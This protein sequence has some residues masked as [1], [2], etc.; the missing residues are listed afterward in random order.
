MWFLC[1]C[2]F[3]VFVVEENSSF[4]LIAWVSV[5]LLRLVLVHS[6]SQSKCLNASDNRVAVLTFQSW[7]S[8]C[9]YRCLHKPCKDTRSNFLLVN[10]GSDYKPSDAPERGVCVCVC[11]GGNNCGRGGGVDI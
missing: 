10:S 6:V 5:H 7:S 11:D 8:T 4:S 1:F 3:F 9:N 2:L